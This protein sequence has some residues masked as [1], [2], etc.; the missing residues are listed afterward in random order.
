MKEFV[1]H[2]RDH[3]QRLKE[4]ADW[5]R[6]LTIRERTAPLQKSPSTHRPLTEAEIEVGQKRLQ[7]WQKHPLFRDP[8]HFVW[9]LETSGIDEETLATLLAESA[10]DIK[11]RAEVPSWLTDLFRAYEL[12]ADKENI[13]P[14][15]IQLG[16]ATNAAFLKT[17][18]PLLSQGIERLW[19]RLL[20]L[21]ERYKQAPFE[22][23]EIMP[24][25]CQYL[26]A[27]IMP[28]LLRTFVLEL[29]VARIQGRL[30]GETA[31]ERFDHF[32]QILKQPEGILTLLK[33]Y[34]VLARVLVET[35][36]RWL[37]FEV[38]W[39]E[40]L[41]ADWEEICE[42]FPEARSAGKLKQ[43]QAGEGDFHRGGRSVAILTW[44]SGF[45][46]VYKPRSVGVEKHFQDVLTWMNKQGYNPAFRPITVIHKDKYGWSE[47]VKA[48]SCASKEEIERFYQRQGGYLA[49][50]YAL[51]ATDFHAEN[52]IAAGEQPVLIDLEALLSPH[53][54]L[55]LEE[56][57]FPALETMEH[58]VLRIGFLPQKIWSNGESEGIDISGLGGAAGQ[59][60]PMEVSMWENVNTD[61]MA[62][63]RKPMTL[64]LA[65]HRPQ[66]QDQEEIDT[67]QFRDQIIDGFTAAYR[68]ILRHRELFLKKMLPLFADD[69]VRCLLRNTQ[70]YGILLHDSLHPDVLRDTLDR[71]RYFDRLWKR[72]IELQPYLAQVI[73]FEVADLSAGD[74]PVFT[75]HPSS[76][77]LFS[78]HGEAMPD[79]FETPSLEAARKRIES[80]SEK[81]LEIQTWIIKGTFI[82]LSIDKGHVWR[83]SAHLTPTQKEANYDRI[84]AAARAVGDRIEQLA[85]HYK[86][87]VGWLGVSP[88]HSIDWDVLPADIDLY[89]GATGIAY[90]LAYLGKLTGEQRYTNLA[91]AA[92]RST[93]H[94]LFTQRE[95]FKYTPG[96]GAFG[97][98]GSYIYL[99]THLGSIWNDPELYREAE[100]VASW[101]PD[102][103]KKDTIYDVMY[104][105]AGCLGALLSLYAVSPAP[106]L[107]EIALQ[108]GDHLLEKAVPQEQGLGWCP[109]SDT[110]PLASFG[111]GNAG[112][113]LFLLRLAEVSGE[114]RF[115]ETAKAA[116]EYERTLYMPEN[117]N[118]L[119]L[120]PDSF[121]PKKNKTIEQRRQIAMHMVAWCNGA[122]GIGLGRLSS[123]HML[124]DE[125]IRAEINNALKT[126]LNQGFGLNHCLC[127]GDMGSIDI[128]LC[129]IQAGIG[130]TYLQEEIRQL[131]PMLLESIEAQGWITGIPQGVETPGLMCGIS[132]TGYA[133]LRLAAPDKVPSILNLSGPVKEL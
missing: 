27:L 66:M 41:C 99:L 77:A 56:L 123:W 54:K 22:L 84:I 38:E 23:D 61:E 83:P 124:Q 125:Q 8:K 21:R 68:L 126:T 112:I 76:R 39:V 108:C 62:L 53:V 88:I 50:L 14:F 106:A 119:D 104:G 32:L 13:L 46:L 94:Q 105:T 42:A 25:L 36:N 92:V 79:F 16:N 91:Q 6:A 87:M 85:I 120:R 52:I 98:L 70:E 5:Y 96:I 109:M 4:D 130:V 67:L 35:I 59:T 71:E 44:S 65:D 82:S 34:N 122:A 31:E 103:I 118:W 7:K 132:G 90:F 63:T 19:E 3:I 9:R 1:A 127:H 28:K 18:Q 95:V 100:E 55:K 11:A 58:S 102:L 89:S 26:V 2:S 12:Y 86:D 17:I 128:L 97:G 110:P 121:D 117:G 47:Y 81:D 40:R 74:V 45:K 57:V 80:F 114:Q 78:S 15:P 37:E 64:S 107:L 49:L 51:E 43:I 60:L 20:A 72:G 93:R 10:E 33:E 73:P 24:N 116:M 75:A 131:T 133:L 69:E 129:A 115:I 101:L 111:H 48:G 29:N 113:A 30:E